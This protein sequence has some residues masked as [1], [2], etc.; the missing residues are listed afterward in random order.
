VTGPPRI[1]PREFV[2]QIAGAG[3]DFFTGVPD[4]LLQALCAYLETSMPSESHVIA[5][6][7]GNAVALAAGHYLAS[8]HP[9]LVYM[10]NSGLGNAVNP[11]LSLTHPD[12]Y[13][14]PVLLVV[15]W[16]GEPGTHDEPQ[17]LAAGRLT[18]PLLSTIGVTSLVLDPAVWRDQV[19]DGL[20]TLGAGR[21]AALVVRAGT[22]APYPWHPDAQEFELTRE[23]VLEL[24]VD[25]IGSRALTVTTTGKTSREMFEIRRRLGQG[26]DRD[27]LT[28]GSMG[29]TASIALGLAMS[30]DRP[31]Y[32]FDGDGSA[33]MHLGSM[34]VVAAAGR[35]NL[36]YILINN[37]AHESVGGQP[38][39]ARTADMV[40]VL[41]AVGF[42][43]VE[44]VAS[45]AELG[46]ALGRLS[47]ASGGALVVNVRQGS[48]P[49]LGRP[50]SSPRANKA[51]LMRLLEQDKS[52]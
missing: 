2:G 39:A 45:L 11:L 36:K 52:T 12:V 27:F 25:R 10:Q 16:R 13:D 17:H 48:R 38:T 7:E 23:A 8:G 32:C 4:S 18:L 35:P 22:F 1:D 15:G 42:G 5:A 33:L 41:R 26:H 44:S 9:A 6:N 28:V 20:A 40:A 19:A 37:R 34:A 47:E 21:T 50:E 30:T 3:V 51:A 43:P 49:D 29:H 24:A 46:P 14:I 31:V